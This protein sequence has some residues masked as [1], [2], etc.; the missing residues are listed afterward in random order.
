[1]LNQKGFK[2]YLETRN[3]KDAIEAEMETKLGYSKNERTDNENYRNGYYTERTISTEME[4][5][6]LI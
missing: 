6:I 2:E 4:K 3:I 1:M 5:S